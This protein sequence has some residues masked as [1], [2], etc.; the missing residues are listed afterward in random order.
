MDELREAKKRID[1]LER[2]LSDLVQYVDEFQNGRPGNGG[3][4]NGCGK[5]LGWPKYDAV[6]TAQCVLAPRPDMNSEN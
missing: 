6:Y 4:C 1:A 5:P 2:A 3:D